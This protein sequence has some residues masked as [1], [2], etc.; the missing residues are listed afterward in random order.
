MGG[1]TLA[2]RL[3]R[4]VCKVAEKLAERTGEEGPGAGAATPPGCTAG[5]RVAGTGTQ[6][7]TP[8]MAAH[9]RPSP[10]T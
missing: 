5:T 1:K 6:A 2:V 3:R 10:A 7:S 4:R 8:G 9:P